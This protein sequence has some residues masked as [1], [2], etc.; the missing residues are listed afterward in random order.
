[1]KR[2]LLFSHYNKYGRL[3]EHVV[4][5]LKSL[6]RYYNRVV[7]V[8]NSSISARDRKRLTGLHSVIIM[9][10]NTGYDFA[11]WRDAMDSIGWGHL[12]EYDSVTIMNDTCF[13]P[14]FSFDNVFESMENISNDF[15]GL[16]AHR[17]VPAVE[18]HNGKEIPKHLQ[19]FFIT[20][21][22]QV[23][24]S[25]VFKSFWDG[26]INYSDVNAV[27][28]NYETQLTQLL[29]KAGFKYNAFLDTSDL[30]INSSKGAAAGANFT[31]YA[32][33]KCLEAKVPLVKI[34][35]FTHHDFP[36]YLISK[37]SS[38]TKFPVE[39]IRDYFNDYSDPNQQ[40]KMFDKLVVQTLTSSNGGKPS[41]GVHLHAFYM[42]VAEEFIKRFEKWPF[43][44]DLFVTVSNE[45]LKAQVKKILD[46]YKVIPKEII[47]LPNR[48][49][50]VIPWIT[51]A[52]K[53]LHNYDIAGHFHTKK[54]AHMEEWVGKVWTGDLMKMLVDPAPII[55][56]NFISNN[57][58]GIVIPDVPQ[59]SRYLGAEMYYSMHELRLI[60]RSLYSRMTIEGGR[61]VDLDTILAFIYPQGMM[62]WY[63]PAALKPV[64]DLTFNERE[65]PY[66]K[67]PDTSVL[68]AIERLFVYV[69]WGMGYDYRISRLKDYTSE[70]ITTIAVNKQAIDIERNRPT[71][72]IGIKGALKDKFK[73]VAVAQARKLP[74]PIKARLIR[75]RASTANKSMISAGPSI[76]LFSHELSNT[77]GPRVALDL[78]TQLKNDSEL[79][80][81]SPELYVPEGARTDA[82]LKGELASRG[83]TIKYFRADNL[84]LSKGDIVI[85]NTF[86]YAEGVFDV[87]LY[88]LEK[89][90]LEHVYLYP[91]EFVVDS[92]LSA[93]TVARIGKMIAQKKLT[94]Y[95]SAEQARQVYAKHFNDDGIKLMPNRI[96]IDVGEI[97]SRKQDD[98]DQIRFVIT[99]T[100]DARKG[101]L[102]VVYAFTSFYYNY[103]RGNENRYRDFTLTIVGLT[104]NIHD[105]YNKLY[106]D[107]L[108]VAAKGL[109][110]RVTLY[111]QQPERKSLEI[112]KDSNFTIL[113]SLY[114]N[115]PRVVFDG[116]AYGHPVLRNDCS[117]YEEQLIDGVNGWKTSSEDWQGLVNA[118][119]DILNK[120]KTTNVKL[121]SMSMESAKIARRYAS[122]KYV[123]IEDIKNDLG[124]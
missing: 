103:Y 116:L 21:N 91:H 17:R 108:R 88:N 80:A 52:N 8:S 55:I 114:E 33:E 46:K 65:V 59:H 44:F 78:F 79:G 100:P 48:G 9:R 107:R 83:I 39:I 70:F 67:L 36:K 43:D 69:A 105:V 93:S 75:M 12:G 71:I 28:M 4:F 20:F 77:G 64:T 96:D 92:Y 115:L 72:T 112:I 113:Y 41:V 102:D 49:Y 94:I 98:F 56:N 10:A 34:K 45:D 50:A 111:N 58:L 30:E 26:V 89:G 61:T 54:D 37:I 24:T 123:V 16:V 19:S 119:E 1:M 95:A 40:L 82:D 106:S 63:R 15:W 117:G 14:V 84:A 31:I 86:A 38:G 3:S 118:I 23:V 97:F 42:D 51:V 122:V 7:F 66:G 53:F 99:G 120:K 101:E 124:N 121:A 81:F 13:G 90:V 87:V 85:M 32:P 5:Q 2:L 73:R 11:A 29:F 62:Y 25:A 6:Q 60:I 109:G 47:V 57:K 104:N 68:H 74:K 76:K 110:G 18:S 22:K 35:A 27:I